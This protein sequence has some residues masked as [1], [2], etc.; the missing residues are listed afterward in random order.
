M[1]GKIKLPVQLYI[2]VRI[3]EYDRIMKHDVK[4]KVN[5]FMREMS[6]ATCVSVFNFQIDL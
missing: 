4:L 1:H 3:D 5:E 2:S 6:C